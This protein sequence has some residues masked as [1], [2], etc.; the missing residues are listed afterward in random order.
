MDDDNIVFFY[1]KSYLLPRE[2]GFFAKDIYERRRIYVVYC[3]S[4]WTAVRMEENKEARK[5]EQNNDYIRAC[6]RDDCSRDIS[7]DNHSGTKR[8]AFDVSWRNDFQG[9]GVMGDAARRSRT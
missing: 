7:R 1:K 9:R 4:A 8:R 2:S 3:S 5:C 6:G